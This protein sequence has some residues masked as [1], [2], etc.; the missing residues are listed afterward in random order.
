ML[1]RKIVV[2]ADHVDLL[3]KIQQYRL[4]SERCSCLSI[5]WLSYL[6]LVMACRPLFFDRF[7][8]PTKDPQ[9]IL[10]YLSP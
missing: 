1:D 5:G 4:I 10:D 7:R 3:L 2:T 8:F 9:S 6:K